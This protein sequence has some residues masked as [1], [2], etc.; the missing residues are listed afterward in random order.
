VIFIVIP[1][2]V[3]SEEYFDGTPRAFDGVCVGPS[4]RVDEVD[5]VIDSPMSV[6]LLAEIAVS[7]PAASNTMA[8]SDSG[9]DIARNYLKQLP[10]VSARWHYRS[11]VGWM[12]PSAAGTTSFK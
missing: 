12:L 8:P 10:V 7:S 1:A 6:T 5:A 3:L 9:P 11:E 4:V 2:I